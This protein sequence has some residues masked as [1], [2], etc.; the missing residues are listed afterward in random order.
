ME[1]SYFELAYNMTFTVQYGIHP[2]V[3]HISSINANPLCEANENTAAAAPGV[4]SMKFLLIFLL[5]H[6][7]VLD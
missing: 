1:N 4:G 6:S 7:L 3:R 2:T 5:L